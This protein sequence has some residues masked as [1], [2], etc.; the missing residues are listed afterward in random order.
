MQ[1]P[2]AKSPPNLITT[3]KHM[4]RGGETHSCWDNSWYFIAQRT[5]G[6]WSTVSGN[7]QVIGFMPNGRLSL[8]TIGRE[9][10][11]RTLTNAISSQ[12]LGKFPLN[13]SS[14]FTGNLW[15]NTTLP[16]TI[17]LLQ[18]F[19]YFSLTQVATWMGGGCGIDT[20]MQIRRKSSWSRN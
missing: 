9:D 1:K 13:F 15:L 4:A 12:L 16:K 2:G 5:V 7:Q 8:V 6:R 20:W 14:K 10:Q 3:P 17:S 18:I 11:Q 19:S